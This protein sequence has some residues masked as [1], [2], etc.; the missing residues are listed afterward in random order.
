VRVAWTEA[1][2]AE[3]ARIDDLARTLGAVAPLALATGRE[4]LA[5]GEPHEHLWRAIHGRAEPTEVW[6]ARLRDAHTV[7]ETLQV[8]SR[9]ARVNPDHLAL[10]LGRPPEARELRREWWNRWR[11]AGR[12]AARAVRALV[13][14]RA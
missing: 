11:R 3:R 10:R 9:S 7:R 5:S 4:E 1:D 13:V 2:A 8:L 6:R 14:G 12:Y